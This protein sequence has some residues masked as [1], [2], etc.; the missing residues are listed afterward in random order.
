[1]F[2]SLGTR[3]SAV[4][5]GGPSQ[6]GDHRLRQLNERLRSQ[7]AEDLNTKSGRT[8]PHPQVIEDKTAL[9][10]TF[11]VGLIP[12]SSY[13]SRWATRRLAS[14]LEPGVAAS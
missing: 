4:R 9:D 13:V 3:R 7:V 11:A 12:D 5:A 14:L 10:V 2:L 1:M 6:P 8:L